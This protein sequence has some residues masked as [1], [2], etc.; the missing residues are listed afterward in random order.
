MGPNSLSKLLGS[1]PIVTIIPSEA[2]KVLMVRRLQWLLFL[3]YVPERED[4]L[5]SSIAF[6]VSAGGACHDGHDS[7]R[8]SC[9]Q[10][11]KISSAEQAL[12][13]FVIIFNPSF[14]T[15]IYKLHQSSLSGKTYSVILTLP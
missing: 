15:T 11:P 12:M 5:L 6:I 9:C 2:H 3:L 10:L 1:L 8:L 7:A 14:S 13:L 4:G